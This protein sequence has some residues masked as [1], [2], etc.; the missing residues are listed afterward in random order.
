MHLIS[1]S[2]HKAGEDTGGT[3]A[4]TDAGTGG[5]GDN[6]GTK[7]AQTQEAPVQR[8]GLPLLQMQV[9]AFV[10]CAD[11][12]TSAQVHVLECVG[13]L[14]Q[15]TTGCGAG[16]S[17]TSSATRRPAAPSHAATSDA[18]FSESHSRDGRGGPATLQAALKDM[19]VTQRVVAARVNLQGS[20]QQGALR[21][22]EWQWQGNGGRC[23]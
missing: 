1:K 3:G 16:G 8:A 13:V 17:T 22:E 19:D 21:Q 23:E 7:L 11:G 12:R 2:L 15:L 18:S 6:G 20:M 10:E 14:T 4:D 9:G 5:T